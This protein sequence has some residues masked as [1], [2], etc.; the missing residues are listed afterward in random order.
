MSIIST[1]TTITV[2][3]GA[4]LLFKAGGIARAIDDAGNVYQIGLNDMIMG[5][6]V[7]A[8]TVEVLVTSGSIE[9]VVDT[10]GDASDVVKFD[11]Y[12]G[13]VPDQAAAASL[14]DAVS[15]VRSVMICDAG[16]LSSTVLAGST[17]YGFARQ[18]PF[19]F[20]AV[21]FGYIHAG[22]NGA[23]SSVKICVASSDDVGPGDYSA[24]GTDATF[25]KFITPKRGGTET[26]AL[27]A[28]SGYTG[29]TPV[30]WG[31]AASGAIA[32]PGANKFAI[33]W[34]DVVPVSAAADVSR[35][36][37]YNLLYRSYQA[38]GDVATRASYAG[39]TS[40]TTY[41]A[42]AGGPSFLYAG[43][44]NDNVTDPSTWSVANTASLGD[45]NVAP[46]VVEFFGVSG[47]QTVLFIGDS[48]FDVSTELAATAQF[49]SV[50]FLFEH[51][52]DNGKYMAVRSG[53]S[54]GT[55]AKYSAVGEQ[56]M[57]A[58]F[59]HIQN[60]IYNVYTINDGLPT[61][62]IIEAAKYRASRFLLLCAEKG[63]RPVLCDW[64][65]NGSSGYTT[66]QIAL[67]KGL[68]DW[69]EKNCA[70][71]LTPGLYYGDGIGAWR[72]GTN[73][74]TSHGTQ[75]TYSDFAG[76][77]LLALGA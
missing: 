41:R 38:S 30:T 36:G 17:T 8:Q 67:L 14:R 21:R 51:L 47:V 37:F 9:Y 61:A 56:I 70:T 26:N 4:L 16:T 77:V 32:D 23:V 3:A 48:R 49:A 34:S 5:P 13:T 27:S 7:K 65:P 29:W 15:A 52:S 45:N 20:S 76:K 25:K 44:S 19:A 43:R 53:I 6:Y 60:A 50:P 39:M 57:S 35:P 31:G 12:G 62:A 75:A 40:G 74:D 55:S 72:A 24:G 71:V 68:S 59:G 28:D 10:D 2:P 22:G 18:V 64:W 69:C 54:G 11:R 1:N 46:L 33:L 58:S 66:A 42:A 63:V 73:F